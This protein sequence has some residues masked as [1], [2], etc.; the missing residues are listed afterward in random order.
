MGSQTPNS[1]RLPARFVVQDFRPRRSSYKKT[2]EATV[3]DHV[4]EGILIEAMEP[5][6]N[7]R[8]GEHFSN[9]EYVQV[10]D[11]AIRKKR[12]MQLLVDS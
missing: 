2:A 9:I 12:V 3:I 11:S 4:L 5:P 8:Q 1:P 7:R 10:V 6:Q